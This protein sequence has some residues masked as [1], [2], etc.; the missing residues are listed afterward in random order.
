METAAPLPSVESPRTMMTFRRDDVVRWLILPGGLCLLGL[1]CLAI[2]L[3][4]ARFFQAKHLPKFLREVLDISETFG[5][6][7]GVGAIALALFVVDAGRR[8]WIPALLLGAYG[9]GLAADLIKVCMTR[10][11]PRNMDLAAST[12]WQTFSKQHGGE[13]H[14]FPSAHTATA[15]GLAVV[16][17]A[18]YPRGRWLFFLYAG[19]TGLH[20]MECSAHYP[21]DVCVGAA[22]GWLIGQLALGLKKEPCTK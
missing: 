19:L 16:L 17:A 5:H 20:R 18:M 1:I 11:R 22:V 14:S 13:S 9:G 6:A 2:D 7:V 15:F 8:S 12:L 3:P 4:L 10:I 21:S